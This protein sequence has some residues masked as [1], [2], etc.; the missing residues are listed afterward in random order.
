MK[1]LDPKK[2]ILLLAAAYSILAGAGL[3]ILS[4]LKKVFNF[5]YQR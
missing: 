2:A 1:S 3:L 4:I 5:P